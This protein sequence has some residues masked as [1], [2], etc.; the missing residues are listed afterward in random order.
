[1]RIGNC[2][3]GSEKLRKKNG[4]SDIINREYKMKRVQRYILN[5]KR[6]EGSGASSG[7]V[8]LARL[9]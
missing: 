6:Y 2:K 9:R 8:C 1:M 7:R 4:E 5:V 3:G